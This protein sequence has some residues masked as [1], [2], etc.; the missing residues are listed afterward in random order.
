MGQPVSTH[1][2]KWHT[3]T[4][5]CF[6]LLLNMSMLRTLVLSTY[7]KLTTIVIYDCSITGDTCVAM[8]EWVENPMAHTALDDILPCVDN[9]TAQETM[10]QSKDVT[11]QLVGMVNNIINNISNIDPPS[12]P[13][14]LNYNQSG[15]LVPSLCNPLTANKTDRICQ[16]GELGFNNATMVWRAYVCQVSAND[17]CA[18]VGRLTPKMYKQM[19]AAV[20]VSD[21]LTEYGPFLTGLLDCTFVRKTFIGIHK[22]H[23][24][25]LNKFSEW[26]YIGL[27]MASA[28]V[29]LSLVL[30]VVYARERKH[31]RYTKLVIESAATHQQ[32]M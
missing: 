20:N 13:S 31:R 1:V 4:W 16:A 9:A 15:P 30:W 28:A 32:R 11:Y 26:V 27:A 6:D 23:C 2:E 22:D 18:T 5:T 24:P 19:S 3:S 29:M 8:N 14:F 7:S 10:S 21:G 25:D 12:F 17:T